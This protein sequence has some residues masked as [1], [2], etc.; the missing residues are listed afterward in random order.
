LPFAP[1]EIRGM[2][3]MRPYSRRFPGGPAGLSAGEVDL[4]DP[5]LAADPFPVYETLREEGKIAFLRDT[6]VT[7]A[8]QIS[9]SPLRPR[10]C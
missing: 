3:G 4:A 8:F 9:A 7:A 6:S 5:I 1:T 2:T 10:N